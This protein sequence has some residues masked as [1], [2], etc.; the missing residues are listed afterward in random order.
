MAMNGVAERA[1]NRANLQKII[2]LHKK[3]L[4]LEHQL[5]ELRAN[6][7]PAQLGSST[8]TPQSSDQADAIEAAHERA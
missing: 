1:I 8:T 3:N 6:G 5:Q 7:D 2:T 4:A